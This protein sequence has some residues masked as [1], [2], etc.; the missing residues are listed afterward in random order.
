MKDLAFADYPE[1]DIRLGCKDICR[2]RDGNT[3]DKGSVPAMKTEKLR[4]KDFDG[5]VSA[6]TGRKCPFPE[7]H[8]EKETERGNPGTAN[9]WAL[10]SKDITR[11]QARHIPRAQ[12]A[13]DKEWDKLRVSRTWLEDQM[14]ERHQVQ[15]KARQDGIT[16]HF[17]RLHDIC[18][19]TRSELPNAA[20]RK[21]KGRVV[22]G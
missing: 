14:M 11:A 1:L 8:R 6:L 7:T 3:Y 2:H 17:G 13:L 10:A 5:H 19:E 4:A 22:F 9:F 16:V 15:K 20:D 18:V 21:Y 12:G